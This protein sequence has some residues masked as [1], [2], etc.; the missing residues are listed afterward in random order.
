MTKL[1]P[2]DVEVIRKMARMRMRYR[3]IAEH[4]PVGLAQIS[5]IVSGHQ[6]RT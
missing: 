1:T 5:K 6:W 4:F 2:F 3:E